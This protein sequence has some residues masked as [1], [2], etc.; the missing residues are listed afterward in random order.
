MI[1]FEL[2]LIFVNFPSPVDA[3][4]S[5]F[6]FHYINIKYWK[7]LHD[8]PLKHSHILAS[9]L[10]DAAALSFDGQKKKK[11]CKCELEIIA[12]TYWS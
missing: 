1:I 8:S 2:D 4:F 10:S 6:S 11:K 9:I 12:A 7:V 5:A 3:D